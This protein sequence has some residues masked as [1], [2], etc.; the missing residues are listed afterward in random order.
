[1]ARRLGSAVLSRGRL[2]APYDDMEIDI[3]GQSREA[4]RARR[5][6]AL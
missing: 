2:P 1:V 4:W 5:Q 3:W 6:T